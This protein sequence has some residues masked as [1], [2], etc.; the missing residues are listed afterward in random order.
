MTETMTTLPLDIEE[1]SSIFIAISI[2]TI[3]LLSGVWIRHR[4]TLLTQFHLPGSVIAG[5]VALLL[6]PEVLGRI[7]AGLPEIG[8]T[9]KQGLFGQHV[10]SIWRA[11]PSLLINVVFAS[12]F[13][14]K[15]IP[16]LRE[17]WRIAGPVVCFGQTIAWGQYVVGLALAIFVLTP[18]F[19]I[20]PLVGALIEISFEGG[21]GTAAGLAPTFEALDFPEG[22]DFA[23]GLATVGLLSAIL[24][25]ILLIKWAEK[26]NHLTYRKTVTTTPDEG[27][28]ASLMQST[29]P[30]PHKPAVDLPVDPLTYHFGLVAISIFIGWLILEGLVAIERMTWAQSGIEL[31]THVPLFPLAMIGGAIMQIS[32]EKAGRA[33]F[34]DRRI[35]NHI[36]G[37][38]LDL[39][40]VA[41]LASLSLTAISNNIL[42]F[43]IVAV[44]GVSWNLIGFLVLAP[45]MLP[46]DWFEQGIPNYGQSMGMTVTGLMLLN[47]V[48]PKNRSGAMESFGYK[49]LMFE[50]IV[51]GGLFTAASLPLIYEFGAMAVFIGV[52]IMAL[53]WAMAG[54]WIRHTHRS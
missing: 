7:A 17:I 5:F 28:T 13:L 34:T 48:D 6:G 25:G 21:H 39:V 29:E 14:G 51:G 1:V 35:V 12:L 44:A 2:L 32:M 36:S 20:S 26:R 49:Q 52:C 47:M 19:D 24:S 46:R 9:L 23:L 27:D 4:S 40:I 50:P 10:E 53:I 54:F 42:P 30:L 43:V 3:L 45:R 16:G 31:F 22:T 11:I 18:F 15:Q 41:A 33:Q 8:D 37:L 38:T